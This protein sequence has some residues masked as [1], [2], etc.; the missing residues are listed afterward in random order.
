MQGSIIQGLKRGGQNQRAGRELVFLVSGDLKG[1]VKDTH[2]PAGHVPGS[3]VDLEPSGLE[4]HVLLVE[5]ALSLARIQLIVSVSCGGNHILE[6][7]SLAACQSRN[8][9]REI[10]GAIVNS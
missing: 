5:R 4:D 8:L 7:A 6:K 2:L 1:M 3:H 9:C 10:Y